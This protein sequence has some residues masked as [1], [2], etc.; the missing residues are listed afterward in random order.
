MGGGISIVNAEV[1]APNTN[2]SQ[3]NFKAAHYHGIGIWSTNQFDVSS[4]GK[5][6]RIYTNSPSNTSPTLQVAT[7]VVTIL[8]LV[9][10]NIPTHADEAAATS[11]GLAQNTVY[12]TSTGELRIKL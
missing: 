9:L 11:A 4:K 2:G 7:D 3:R 10:P 8:K 6:V 12:K 1:N 5:L